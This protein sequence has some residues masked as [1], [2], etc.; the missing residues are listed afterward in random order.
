M[1]EFH[2]DPNE[3]LLRM[4]NQLLQRGYACQGDSIVVVSDL[5]VGKETLHAIHVHTLK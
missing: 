1:I 3:N 4:Q 5:V 2:D